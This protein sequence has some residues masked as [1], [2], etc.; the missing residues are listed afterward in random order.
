MLVHDE[1]QSSSVLD[2]VLY[3]CDALYN[4]TV[5]NI[6]AEGKFVFIKLRRNTRHFRNRNWTV[7]Y[8]ETTH[9]LW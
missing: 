8:R 9:N 5:N 2:Q 1:I 3:D 7:F 6:K 4:S